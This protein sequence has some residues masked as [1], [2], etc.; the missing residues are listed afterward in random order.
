MTPFVS[1]IIPFYNAADYIPHCL[2]CVKNQ[3]YANFEVILI[4][5]GSSD[6]SYNLCI[7][8]TQDDTRFHV[9][10]QD[11]SGPSAARNTGIDNAHGDAICFMDVDDEIE[12]NYISGLVHDAKENSELVLQGMIRFSAG[13]TEDRGTHIDK[14]YHLQNIDEAKKLFS[15][16]NIERF[17][18]PY[19]KLYYSGLLKKH[20]LHFNTSIRLAED[21]DFLLQYLCVCTSVRVSSVCHYRY[22][23]NEGSVSSHLNSFE[24]EYK[25]MCALI[26]TWNRFV[27]KYPFP[28]LSELRSHSIAYY[29]YRCLFS[30]TST[31]DMQSIPQEYIPIFEQ[32]WR[33]DT[34]YLMI[35][36]WLFVH[37][38]YRLSNALLLIAQKSR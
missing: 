1:L 11:N 29:V 31:D 28:S 14:T 15:D 17:G 38:C 37:H 22:V 8:L 20:N 18:G 25:G 10:H 7:H 16:I 13:H 36:K 19:C 23:A 9:I 27:E 2:E 34:T 32:H 6:G 3:D 4:D 24:T 12:S 33:A 21:L 30:S 35:V 5:D 26:D